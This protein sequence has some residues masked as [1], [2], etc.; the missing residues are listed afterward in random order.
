MVAGGVFLVCVR[1]GWLSERW[2]G[3]SLRTLGMSLGPK[4][5]SESL[6]RWHSVGVLSR[7]QI[8]GTNVGSQK[9]R[10]RRAPLRVE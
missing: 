8:V 3:F 1:F 7:L 2:W 10:G 4:T 6:F 5:P 9:L